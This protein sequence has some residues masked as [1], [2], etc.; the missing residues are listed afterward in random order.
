MVGSAVLC[1][2][3]SHDN[4]DGS[5]NKLSST[6]KSSLSVDLDEERMSCSGSD[7]CVHGMEE[8]DI[9]PIIDCNVGCAEWCLVALADGTSK[10]AGGLRRGDIVE[11]R[12]GV[13]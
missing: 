3:F 8:S 12:V 2:H 9:T 4:S 11:V 1:R 6:A 10:P 5:F 7:L 13:S